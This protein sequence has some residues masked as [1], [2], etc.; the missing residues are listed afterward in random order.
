MVLLGQPVISAA[1]PDDAGK[2]C[3]P[4]EPVQDKYQYLR[5]LSLAVMGSVPAMEK[6][7]ALHDLDD[8]PLDWIN[9]WLKSDKFAEQVARYHVKFLWNRVGNR[10]PY[11]EF[12]VLP[13]PSSP[14]H[15]SAIY[16]GKIVG[17]L[18]EPVEYDKNGN[19]VA[20]W[21][22]KHQAYQEGYVVV[23]P[24]WD[25]DNPMKVCAYN[26]QET[27]ISPTGTECGTVASLSDPFCG[28][29]PNLQWCSPKGMG[30]DILK[31]MGQAVDKTVE[32]VIKEGRPYTDLFLSNITYVNGPLVHMWRYFAHRPSYLDR[33]HTLVPLAVDPDI[34]P[35]LK[36]TDVDTWVPVELS[37]FHAGIFTSP[38]YLL[39][40]TTNR[41]RGRQFYEAF[42][43]K[44]FLPPPGGLVIDD[45]GVNEPDLQERP[46]C[47]YCHKTLEPAGAYW[48][49]WNGRGA[50]YL[51][52]VEFP[53][54]R[55]DCEYCANYGGCTFNCKREYVLSG[56]TSKEADYIG[57]LH[58][59]QF[60]KKKHHMHV[61]MG[62]KLLFQKNIVNGQIASCTAK[63][64]V[65][66][67]TRRKV[68]A[69]DADWL[70]KLASQFAASGYDFASLVRDIVTDPRF[71]RSL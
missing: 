51:N 24:Y 60:L 3:E 43:C 52:P 65:E 11:R 7:T 31:Y 40:F 27:L 15:Q 5:S 13:A 38:A 42:L 62:P 21:S 37:P 53:A 2:S 66:W 39:R 70:E 55:K 57:W 25:L 54:Y 44:P 20:K 61:E 32:G 10:G 47:D 46:G 1:I 56:F 45:E 59:Y 8:V 36:Y 35:N 28:C 18:N 9:T 68:R 48:G 14:Y 49:R 23:A 16:R 29:G 33:Q 17:C 41:R 71:R 63:N 64:A 6:Y 26:A 58:A 22:E 69:W 4:V 12:Q 19:I 50:G 67:L 30:Q 34:L